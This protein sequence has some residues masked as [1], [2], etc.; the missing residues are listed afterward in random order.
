M[1]DSD[2]LSLGRERETVDKRK[3]D[4]IRAHCMY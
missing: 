2:C 1:W 4:L 3:L